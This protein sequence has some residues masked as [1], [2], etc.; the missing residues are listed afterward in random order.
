[1][2][3]ILKAPHKDGALSSLDKRASN[4]ERYT[5]KAKA[6]HPGNNQRS[7]IKM[8]MGRR[9]VK[10]KIIFV[11]FVYFSIPLQLTRLWR[12]KEACRP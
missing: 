10:L 8:G 6:P 2:S 3:N 1:M 7:M 5:E 4:A 12:L 11:F 9:A